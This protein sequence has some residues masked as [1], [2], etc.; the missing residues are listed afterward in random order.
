M[1][2]VSGKIKQI[3][4]SGVFGNFEKRLFWLEEVSEKFANT[5]QLELWQNDCSMIDN[6]KVGDYVTCYIDIKGKSFQKKDG[7]GES[8]INTLKCWNFE[9]DGK[10]F[11]EIKG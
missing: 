10:T 11:K 2:K 5:W 7:S 1:V 9:K 8:V 6:Y 4:E 3:F